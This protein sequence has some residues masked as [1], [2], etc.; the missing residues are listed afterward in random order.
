MSFP[1]SRYRSH[2]RAAPWI[3]AAVAAAALVAPEALLML[4]PVL[5]LVLSLWLG[6]FP[7]EQVIAWA[8]RIV[9]RLRRRIARPATP[10]APAAPPRAAPAGV[11]HTFALAMRPPPL[12]R[13]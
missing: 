2:L 6:V 8:R 7:D 9:R 10:L 1:R 4:S 12:L 11:A 3:G 5:V 13:V